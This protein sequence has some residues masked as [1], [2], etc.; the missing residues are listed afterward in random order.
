MK[1]EKEFP[2]FSSKVEGVEEKFNLFDLEDRRRYF[3]A[4]AGDEIKKLKEYFDGGNTFIAYLLAKKAA[5]KGT[6]TKLLMELFGKDKIEHISVGD[7]VRAVHADIQDEQ[8][9]EELK[10]YLE[11][12]YRGY[13]SI[14]EALNAFL[15]KTQDKLLPT[16]FILA[17]V[18][19]EIDKLDKKTL[20]IDGFPRD[21]DQVSYSLYFRDLINYRGDADIFVLIDIPEAVI[22]ARMQAR[23]VCPKCQTPRNLKLFTTKKVGYDAE[24]NEYYLKCDNP[25]CGDE[26]MRGKEGDNMGIES[27]RDRLELDDKLA[28]KVFS[29]HGIPRV[30]LRNA[31][32]VDKAGTH[33]DEYEIT[34]EYYYERKG[35]TD[36]AE[37]KEKP[38][39]VKDDEGV[40]VYS[41]QAP[42]VAVSLIKQLV[43]NLGL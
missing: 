14:D 31:I 27:I 1:F 23:V 18:K 34:P 7:T 26:R 19:R 38:W 16:E 33:A 32:P 25:E 29:L 15:G 3:E 24:K 10:K 41:L 42:P 22:D 21:L 4:K 8:K 43:K 13:M 9:K 39:V 35:E 40:D 37:I 11:S 20:F 12:N 2:L 28:Q 30:L 17:L 6:Y 5:G 36:E